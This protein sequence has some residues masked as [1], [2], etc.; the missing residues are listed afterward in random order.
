M[1]RFCLSLHLQRK[2]LHLQKKQQHMFMDYITLIIILNMSSW[3]EKIVHS[4]FTQLQGLMPDCEISC[5]GGPTPI[6][7]FKTMKCNDITVLLW[8]R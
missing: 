8:G 3:I 1:L 7:V 2:I 4:T 5:G 6:Y